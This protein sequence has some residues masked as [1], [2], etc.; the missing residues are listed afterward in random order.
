[1]EA[2]SILTEKTAY[3]QK[4][5]QMRTFAAET[6]ERDM[7]SF[8]TKTCLGMCVWGV[9]VAASA[10]TYP[11]KPVRLITTGTP[12]SATDVRARW[13]AP[14]LSVALGQSVVVDTRPGA[15]GSIGTEVAAKSTPDGYTLLIVH[16]G[17]LALNPYIYA[18]VGYD[19]LTSFAPITLLGT[20]AL[21]LAV[22]PSVPASSVADLIE[23][24]KQKPGQLNYGSPGNGTPPHVAV[25][26]F[27]RMAG[28]TVTHVPYKGG[29]P[30]LLELM[31]GRVTFTF[32]G[33]AV[34]V[35]MVKVG[36]IKPLAV[37]SASRNAALPDVRTIAESGLPGYEF[38]AWQ[39][40]A[41][42][43]STPH[44]IV[45]R[46]NAVIVKIAISD[47]A[48]DWFAESGTQPT[49]STPQAFADFIR[50]EHTRWGPVIREAGIK[51]D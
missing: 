36:K 22:H 51:A 20:S 14:R 12:G 40:V 44:N 4:R 34:Q 15:G 10:Q 19:P 30:A 50:Q 26:L 45:S 49:T 5:T 21:L 7:N 29:G 8:A 42:P 27:K 41:A 28:I 3:R 24:A 16:Q 38:T 17:T 48:R 43:A 37:T 1:M 9:A 25:E 2:S 46:L 6:S 33:M 47:E 32:D 13:L 39:G 35:P 11:V 18:R 31:A 23:L